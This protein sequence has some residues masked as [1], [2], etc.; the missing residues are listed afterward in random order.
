MTNLV[1]I[2]GDQ[3]SHGLAALRAA[4]QGAAIVLMMEVGAE[5]T[6][7]GYHQKKLAFLFSAMRHFAEELRTAGFNW[8]QHHAHSCLTLPSS[9][10]FLPSFPPRSGHLPAHSWLQLEPAPWQ[11]TCGLCGKLYCGLAPGAAAGAL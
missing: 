9:L 4:D 2:L 11:A 3:L 10:P 7:V 8:S 5:A 6:H 1:V